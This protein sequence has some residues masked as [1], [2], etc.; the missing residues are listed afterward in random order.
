MKNLKL[1]FKIVICIMLLLSIL[2]VLFI[3]Y[4]IN[5][6]QVGKNIII[7]STFLDDN[8]K[9]VSNF[10]RVFKLNSMG[11]CVNTKFIITKEDINE[12]KE[13]EESIAKGYD[14]EHQLSNSEL[15]GY[16]LYTD[17]KEFNGLMEEEIKNKLYTKYVEEGKSNTKY[18][19]NV[20]MSEF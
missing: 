8:N 2:L 3:T 14:T 11:K 6:K 7:S 15:N 16:T 4:G 20:S 9:I 5:R 17:N 18:K 12:L 1:F 13:L 10:T 19:V